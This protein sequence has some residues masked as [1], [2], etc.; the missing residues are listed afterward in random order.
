MSGELLRG[1]AADGVTRELGLLLRRARAM[2]ETLAREVHPGLD[3]SAFAILHLVACGEAT[4]VTD[5][6]ARLSVGKP[7]ISRQVTALEQLELVRRRP[8]AQDRRAA[9]LELTEMGRASF[10]AARASRE[11]RFR[12]LLAGWSAADLELFAGLLG[13]L[14]R[15]A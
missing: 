3:A 12:R 2:S 7:T 15:L 8:A 11:E 5:L 13:R 4:S 6:A 10:A 1:E 14:N 9:V